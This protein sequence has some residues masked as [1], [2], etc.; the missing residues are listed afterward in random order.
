MSSGLEGPPG[1]GRYGHLR[2]SAAILGL[3]ALGSCATDPAGPISASDMTVALHASSIV[4]GATTRA[5]ALVG[6]AVTGRA[7]TW[8]S[9]DAAI[10]AVSE[11]GIVTG[12]AA[13]GPVTIAATSGAM[14]GTARVT[15]RPAPE[16]FTLEERVPG[17]ILSVN[18]AYSGPDTRWQIDHD[19]LV[20]EWRAEYGDIAGIDVMIVLPT[21]PLVS[22]YASVANR[23][24]RGI[25]GCS[26]CRYDLA[27]D[28]KSFAILDFYAPWLQATSI[29]FDPDTYFSGFMHAL[30]HEIGHYWLAYV[31][32]LTAGDGVHWPNNLD[33]FSG[34]A[35]LGDPMAGSHWIVEGGRESCVTVGDATS[36]VVDRFSNL[37]LYLMGLIPASS[38][39]PIREQLFAPKAGDDHYNLHGPYCDQ[40]HTFTSERTITILDLIALNGTRDPSSEQAQRGFLAAIV[41]VAAKGEPPPPGFIDYVR[42]YR[43]A[44]PEAWSQATRG[45]STMRV[46]LGAR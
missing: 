32:G 24:I 5:T 23:G 22:H 16:V 15:V 35:T 14:S 9:T 43:A 10:A 45:T 30:L 11:A 20:R 31:Q 6:G 26:E 1:K 21:K 2:L 46:S 37:S 44:L 3:S 4:V 41:V 17:A 18:A 40:P 42:S 27:P 28:L 29:G 34:N 39:A 25:G 7:V 13:G 12:V 36:G 38:V 19:E 33:L 8:S